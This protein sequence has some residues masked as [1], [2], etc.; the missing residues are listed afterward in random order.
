MVTALRATSP[1]LTS[2][3]A[4]VSPLSTRRSASLTITFESGINGAPPWPLQGTRHQQGRTVEAEFQL[5]DP[6]HCS[7]DAAGEVRIV[8]IAVLKETDHSLDVGLL[9]LPLAVEAEIGK[10]E[11]VVAGQKGVERGA[12]ME[13]ILGCRTVEAPY[14]R[15]SQRIGDQD[16]ACRAPGSE[17]LVVR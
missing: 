1:M 6:A 4:R 10:V 3:R 17:A 2:A 11:Q 5:K 14:G 16:A 12:A 15:R 8:V 7:V 9:A 13:K